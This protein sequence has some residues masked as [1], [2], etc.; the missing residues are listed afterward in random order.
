MKVLSK[1]AAVMVVLALGLVPAAALANG[2]SHG[3]SKTAPGHNKSTG[4]SSTSKAKAYGKYCQAESKK[5]VA[6]QKGTPFSNCVT[7]MAQLAKSSKS[8]PHTV[9]ANESKKHLAGQKGTPYSDCVS[10]AAK[11]HK[12][13]TS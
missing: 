5:H 4:S 8:N 13:K 9:C 3:K 1:L 12:T 6:G 11:L 7:D 2:S 10:A